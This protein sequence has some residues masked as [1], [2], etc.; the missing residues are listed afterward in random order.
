MK[1]ALRM[2][3][4][5]TVA[6]WALLLGSCG[7]LVDPENLVVRCEVAVG[8]HDPCRDVTGE[9]GE[10]FACIG[11]TCQ[12]CDSDNEIC[13]GRDND[14]DG[15]VDEGHDPD[16]DGFTWC[17]GG[18]PELIDCVPTDPDV[19]PPAPDALDDSDTAAE[20]C[21]GK[22]ND[23][24]GQIDESPECSGRLTCEDG[25]P[26]DLVCDTERNRCVT[27]RDEGSTCGSDVDCG[28]GFCV[29]TEA[30]GLTDV[31]ADRL[32]GSACC[33]DA[34][35]GA[36]DVCVHS[37]SG[38]RVCLP[39][40]QTGRET[41]EEGESCNRSSQCASGVCDGDRCVATCSRD[42]DCG[43]ST[44]RLASRGVSLLLGAGAWVC[45]DAAGRG[46]AGDL[47]T[48]FDPTAC[49]SGFCYGVACT[50][51]CGADADCPDGQRCDYVSVTG[52]F[53]AGRVT[54]C[55]AA[56]APASFSGAACCTNADCPDGARC[57]PVQEGQDW[58]MVCDSGPQ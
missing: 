49:R 29:R 50:A 27:T 57:R 20:A 35:C 26:G 5:C 51:P 41:R 52:L 53:D 45:G 43:G 24:D 14:C 30:L 19:H 1:L 25:C 33:R 22:D 18:R 10:H 8:Q 11:G 7:F 56:D 42:E 9:N 3:A 15:N 39:V 54:A 23:C 44:C 37:G 48:G 32:C 36:G 17:G 55:V 31:L 13:D 34:D 2:S 38:A 28:D 12:I 47:C 21:D 16:G 46:E 40:E 6:F 4:L 58:V